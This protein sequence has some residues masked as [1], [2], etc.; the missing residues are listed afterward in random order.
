MTQAR[1]V[2]EITMDAAIQ[3]ER[4]YGA[5]ADGRFWFRVWTSQYNTGDQIMTAFGI[6]DVVS[7]HA[8]GTSFGIYGYS[9]QHTPEDYD[10][11]ADGPHPIFDA[12][13]DQLFGRFFSTMCPDGELGHSP[14]SDNR[15]ITREQFE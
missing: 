2:T 13:R 12:F 6:A 7:Q 11:P 10:E 5:V 4:D 1:P 14:V 8:R 15:E 3:K 9:L